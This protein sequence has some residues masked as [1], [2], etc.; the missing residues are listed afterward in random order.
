MKISEYPP[1]GLRVGIS[2]ATSFGVNLHEF[3]SVI[4]HEALFFQ[5]CTS[6]WIR[7]PSNKSR[8]GQVLPKKKLLPQPATMVEKSCFIAMHRNLSLSSIQGF[9]IV[10]LLYYPCLDRKVM[11]NPSLHR[12]FIDHDTIFYF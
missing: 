3:Y 10:T 1:P 5:I 2:A 11:F 12:L 4:K 8:L 6:L 9:T 7:E